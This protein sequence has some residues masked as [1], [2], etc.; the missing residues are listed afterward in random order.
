MKL[1]RDL[2]TP[3]ELKTFADPVR[4]LLLRLLIGREATLTQLSR[5]LGL[6]PNLVHYHLKKLLDLDLVTVV[7]R[8]EEGKHYRATAMNVGF[9]PD[10]RFTPD[11]DPTALPPERPPEPESQEGVSVHQTA[12]ALTDDG[13]AALEAELVAVIERHRAGAGEGARL[14]AVTVALVTPPDPPGG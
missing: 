11:A 12:L 2:T 14:R 3:E 8:D 9:D 7:R 10:M 1:Q 5:H 6:K 13:L 4:M